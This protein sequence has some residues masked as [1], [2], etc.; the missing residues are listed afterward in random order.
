MRVRRAFLVLAMATIAN[1]ASADCVIDAKSKT[2]FVVLDSN[3]LLLKGG[4]GSDILI[5][6]FQFFYPSSNVTVLKDSFCD[7]ATDVLYVDGQLVS[8]QAVKQL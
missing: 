6:S 8:V 7:F 2:S 5:K 1:A 4:I 3:T